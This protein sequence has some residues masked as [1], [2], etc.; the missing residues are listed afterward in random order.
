MTETLPGAAP[1]RSAPA[2]PPGPP[3]TEE[4]AAAPGPPRTEELAPGVYAYIQPDGGW[5]VSNSGVLIGDDGVTVVDTTATE[6]RARALRA[7]VGALTTAP[8]RLL[9]NTHFHGDHTF[10][11][12]VVGDGRA[13]VVAHERLRDEAAAAGLGLT[14]LWPGVHWG[15]VSV[16]LPHLT[17]RDRLTLH[18]GEGREAE[19]FHPGPAH[20]TNDTLVWLARERVL[21]AGDVVMPGCTP[22]V[23]MGSIEGSLRTLDRIG[24][25]A[26]QAIVGGHG[27]VSGPE[28]LRETAEYLRRVRR[29][30]EQGR[31]R[32]LTPLQTAREHGPGPFGHWQDPERLVGNLHRAYAELAGEPLGSP[33]DVVGIF[34]ELVEFNGGVLPTCYA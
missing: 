5:C 23:L 18:L 25:L 6:D 34:G 32:G 7:A 21:F 33:L 9:V 14:G 15:D 12:A 16:T 30:A 28:V 20:T 24:E 8:V 26:P 27:P 29:I 1:D 22:F 2:A 19:L 11:N 4:P 13:A 10:G 3:R 17:Y 31:A